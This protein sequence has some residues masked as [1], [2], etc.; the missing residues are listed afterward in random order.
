MNEAPDA[1]DFIIESFQDTK[2]IFIGSSSHRLSNP[3]IFTKENLQR[4]YDAGVRYILDEGG[5]L[6]AD[7]VFTDE[8]MLNLFN[9]EN[10]FMLF[11]PWDYAGARYSPE[12]HFYQLIALFN[13]DKKDEDKI[14]VIGM[15]SGRQNFV[16]GSVDLVSLMNYRDEYMA[17]T[18][19]DFIDNSLPDEKFLVLAGGLHGRTTPIIN[20]WNT[21]S[22]WKPLGVYL[23]E[24]YGNDYLAYYCTTLDDFMRTVYLYQPFFKLLNSQEWQ[25]I[26]D[27]TKYITPTQLERLDELIDLYYS[28]GFDGYIVEKNSEVGFFDSYAFFD[29]EIANMAIKQTRESAVKMNTM[30]NENPYNYSD[31][32]TWITISKFIKNVYYLKLAFGVNFPYD[33]WNP[34]MPVLEALSILES[35]VLAEGINITDK[36]AFQVPPFVD[37]QEYHRFIDFF[38]TLSPEHTPLDT[39]IS[40][41]QQFNVAETYMKRAKELF[42]YELWVDYWYAKMYTELNNH[43]KAYESLQIL[44]ANPLIYSMQIY[45]EVLDMASS[46]ARELRR[47]AD[48]DMYETQK[49]ALWNEFSINVSYFSI[50]PE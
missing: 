20:A 46:T 19:I 21:S 30:L 8:E 4:F 24:K 32:D 15:E 26:T 31:A 25:K 38:T 5:K 12:P 36:M 42:S 2:I 50:F 45:P 18:A 7:P 41:K 23:K 49:S 16:P 22:D 14:K 34:K 39:S 29:P 13:M 44:L 17:K 33:F 28:S 6:V 1:I 27:E 47:N 3:E 9:Q 35:T 10:A 48:A 11:H 43:R 37:L 40:L